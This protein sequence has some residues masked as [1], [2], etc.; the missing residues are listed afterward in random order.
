MIPYTYH[1][2]HNSLGSDSTLHNLD[3]WKKDR[4]QISYEIFKN[5]YNM[6]QKAAKAARCKYFSEL[7]TNNC[8]KPQ[9]LFSSINFVLNPSVQS[10]LEPSTSLCDNFGKF[11]IDMITTLRSQLSKSV[12]TMHDVMFFNLV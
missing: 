8:H 5:S 11:L 6:F 1:D 4:L 10:I 9:V 3:K 7:N 2:V 12:Y